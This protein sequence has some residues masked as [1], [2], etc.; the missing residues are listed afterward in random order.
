MKSRNGISRSAHDDAL[1]SPALPCLEPLRSR[2]ASTGTMPPESPP[3]VSQPIKTVHGNIFSQK[4]NFQEELWYL[5][6]G[7]SFRRTQA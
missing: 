3:T 4:N 5:R 7:Q 1:P 6:K 2:P